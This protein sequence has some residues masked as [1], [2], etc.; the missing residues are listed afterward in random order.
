MWTSPSS[1]MGVPSPTTTVGVREKPSIGRKSPMSA[2]AP[3]AVSS[4]AAP[5]VSMR[6][7]DGI[8][9]STTR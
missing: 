2:E 9:S 5:A 3:L 8:V 1:A 4:F 6:A 7:P